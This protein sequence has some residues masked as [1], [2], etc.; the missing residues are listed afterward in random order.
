MK[1]L[2]LLIIV[3]ALPGSLCGRELSLVDAI[4]LAVQHSYAVRAGREQTA[5]FE[6]AL[7]SARAERLPTLTASATGTYASEVMSFDIE[8]P[9]SVQVSREFGS[10]ETY[11]TTVK[12]AVPLYTGGKLSGGIAFA[13]AALDYHTA[14]ER[15]GVEQVVF[16]ARVEYLSLLRAEKLV[17]VSSASL[18]RASIIR[19]DVEALYA[20]GAA[21]SVDLLEARLA[22]TQ[23]EFG[24]QQARTNRRS[25][26]IRLITLLGLDPSESLQ[27]GDVLS[28]P[29][30]DRF[31]A[32]DVE[33]G[34]SQLQIARAATA[35]S[36]SQVALARSD[37]FPILSAF[38]G[39]TYGK[40]NLD[41]FNNTW[42]DY[43]SFGAALTW[44]FNLGNR[45]GANLRKS[46]H[47]YQT[48]LYEQDRVTEQ[49]NREVRLSVEQLRLA[50]ARYE[51]ARQSHRTTSENY[52]LATAKHR[53]GDLSANRLLEI[54]A[55]LAAAESSLAA[56]LVDYY[57]AESAY[58]YATGSDKLK[59]GL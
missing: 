8:L 54:E 24:V 49:L 4:D 12:L 34:K 13:D 20:A 21:D 40:P 47:L 30:E 53:Q 51:T 36:R 38:G 17:D 33:P 52:R 5:A 15:A 10:K 23:A 2:K 22:V 57:L 50:H 25:A 55:G 37:F 46:R 26:E 19:K 48:S 32:A 59:E 18:E 31:L 29:P 3:L 7:S 41:P 58:Y 28:A 16:A 35:M 56:A 27:T 44:S 39:Y 11:L 42:N 43:F 14:L 9:S 1:R 6:Q 45:S